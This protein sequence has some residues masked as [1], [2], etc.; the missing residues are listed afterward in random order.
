MAGWSC[1]AR[2]QSK[3]FCA[4]LTATPNRAKSAWRHQRAASDR[5]P[6]VHQIPDLLPPPSPRG[7]CRSRWQGNRRRSFSAPGMSLEVPGPGQRL[8]S[9]E[10][11][12]EGFSFSLYVFHR[13][14]DLGSLAVSSV[15]GQEGAKKKPW[16]CLGEAGSREEKRTHPQLNLDGK[17]KW[18]RREGE[19]KRPVASWA[20]LLCMTCLRSQSSQIPLP[21]PAQLLSLRTEF[22]KLVEVPF[23][24]HLVD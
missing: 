4:P 19:G 17:S 15:G 3:Y 24:I 14:P 22:K 2:R 1:L 16:C 10:C 5:A 9:K 11:W 18:H 6:P 8:C 13:E 21:L 20:S 23:S 12:R 7:C